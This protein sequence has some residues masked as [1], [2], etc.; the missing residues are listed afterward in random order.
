MIGVRPQAPGKRAD[1]PRRFETVDA[2]QRHV[3]QHHVV[4][5]RDGRDRFLAGADEI[6]AVAEFGEDGV[7][8]DAA[9]RIVLGAQHCKAAR[10]HGRLL[11]AARFAAASAGAIGSTAEKRNDEPR[12]GVL[13]TVRSPPI[14]L[15]R[16]LDHG[17]AEAGAAVAARDV[18]VRLRERTEQPLDLGAREPDAAVGDGEDE[19]DAAARARAAA[20]PRAAPRRAR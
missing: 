15:A 12:P 20:A 17:E 14:S 6:G 19:F 1:A 5:A 18:G 4:A 10:R 8:D 3:H 2:G 13:V 11:R 16:S 7:E 9:V